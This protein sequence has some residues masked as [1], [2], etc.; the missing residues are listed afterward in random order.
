[1]LS[2]QHA[3][4][5]GG[6]ADVMKHLALVALLDALLRKPRPIAYAETH[7]GRGFYDLGGVEARKT[8]EAAEGIGR[9]NLVAAETR[10]LGAV[11]ARLRATHGPMAYP[12]SPL[13]ARMMLRGQDRMLLFE[14]HP[15]EYRALQALLH[16]PQ[17]RALAPETPAIDAIEA[18]GLSGLLERAPLA[19]RAGLVLVDPSYEI[20]SEYEALPRFL[21]R[22][23]TQWPQA[24]V[25]VWYPLL[26]A[27]R[28]EALLDGLSGLPVLRREMAFDLKDGAG[29]VG[30]GLVVIAPP[31][32]TA[33]RLDAALAE[34]AAILRPFTT[35]STPQ[36]P[37]PPGKT[38]QS[39]RPPRR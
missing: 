38:G 22:L 28:H 16:T 15:A 1:M 14:R 13:I 17:T 26:R 2:Y 12:G 34:G 20:K 39:V 18:D 27:G 25:L 8:G 3:Y 10:S 11:L 5:A 6:P 9:L 7:A 37:A 24:V 19:P 23:I 33:Q 31:H 30:S 4:H 29:M 21:R 32:G 35:G 36:R